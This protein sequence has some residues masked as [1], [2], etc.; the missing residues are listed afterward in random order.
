MIINQFGRKK[1]KKHKYRDGL[2]NYRYEDQQLQALR[3]C[4]HRFS[5]FRDYSVETFHP[6]KDECEFSE[7]S[8]E[9]GLG[10]ND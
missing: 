7:H 4:G 8:S 5:E 9:E 3:S 10:G 2:T 6:P 1:H